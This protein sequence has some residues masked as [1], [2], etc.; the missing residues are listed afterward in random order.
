MRV[1]K[2]LYVIVAMLCAY[3]L[4]SFGNGV[5]L[6]SPDEPVK[7][8]ASYVHFFNEGGET[9]TATAAYQ[10]FLSEDVDKNTKSFVNL[11]LVS[12]PSG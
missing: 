11:G 8:L 2:Y 3:P 9:F 6:V 12:I 7:N 10:R 1:L 5:A 4:V